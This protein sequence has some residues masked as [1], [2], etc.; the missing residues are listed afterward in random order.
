MNPED[1]KNAVATHL[2]REEKPH[3]SEKSARHDAL[4]V[5]HVDHVLELHI[6]RHVGLCAPAGLGYQSLLLIHAKS[7]ETR[8]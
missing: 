5:E 7:H 1:K 4:I 6:L 8:Y 2:N 3:E